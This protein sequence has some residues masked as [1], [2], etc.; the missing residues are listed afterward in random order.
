MYFKTFLV[1]MLRLYT[2]L[3]FFA[4]KKFCARVMIA[5]K[6]V[7]SKS[8]FPKAPGEDFDVIKNYEI[9]ININ[10]IL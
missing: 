9:Q 8:D 6:T 10:D 5:M 4:V 3:G 2:N 1:L 7:F